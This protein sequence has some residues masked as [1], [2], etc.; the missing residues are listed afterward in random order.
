MCRKS[1]GG[2]EM[3]QQ[4]MEFDKE[5]VK[6][7]MLKYLIYFPEDYSS[8]PNKK[9]PLVLY[10][11][12]AGERGENLE[13]VK[14][15]GIPKLAENEPDFQFVAL[16]PLCPDDSSWETHFEALDMLLREVQEKYSIDERK[17]YVFIYFP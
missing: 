13:H 12:G 5:I 9:W 1:Y 7:L 16:S 15:N 6:R 17:V 14:W 3:A 11:H 10:L 2:S 8:S 4:E